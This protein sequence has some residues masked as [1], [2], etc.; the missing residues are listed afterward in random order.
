MAAA[1]ALAASDG[2]DHDDRAGFVVSDHGDACTR[3]GRAVS[4]DVLCKTPGI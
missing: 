2:G 3:V 1:A 4:N